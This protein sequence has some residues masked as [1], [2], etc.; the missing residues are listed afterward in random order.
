[1][2]KKLTSDGGKHPNSY[3]FMEKINE[4]I[5]YIHSKEIQQAKLEQM[6]QHVKFCSSFFGTCPKNL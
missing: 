5:D 2:I 4:I 6:E 3:D 1:M